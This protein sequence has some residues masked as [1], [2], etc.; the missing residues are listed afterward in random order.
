VAP[1]ISD[2]SPG[3]NTARY[4]QLRGLYQLIGL[5]VAALGAA[6]LPGG[7]RLS[8]LWS[9]AGMYGTSQSAADQFATF[10]VGPK[11]KRTTPLTP[12]EQQRK[13]ALRY[14]YGGPAYDAE[15]NPIQ[16][17]RKQQQGAGPNSA[18]SGLFGLLDDLGPF[19][20]GPARRLAPLV[21]K[22]IK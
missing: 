13:E 17:G 16:Q 19:L 6:L 8:Y 3:T 2:T 1:F 22:F 10:F 21:G 18:K 20:Q 12:E 4:R 11:G 14:S 15:G 7:P 5:P 9:A